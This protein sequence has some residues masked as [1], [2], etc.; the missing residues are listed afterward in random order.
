MKILDQRMPEEE[1]F[2]NNKEEARV[3]IERFQDKAQSVLN[4]EEERLKGKRKRL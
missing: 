1:E 2:Y 4:R 3:Y